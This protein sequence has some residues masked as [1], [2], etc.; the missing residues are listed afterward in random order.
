VTKFLAFDEHFRFYTPKF[1]VV[2]VV[3]FHLKNFSEIIP[4]GRYCR[5]CAVATSSIS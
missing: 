3:D 4:W 2:N 5:T 1:F